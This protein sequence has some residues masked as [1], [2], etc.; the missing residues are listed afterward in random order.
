[1][2]LIGKI[3]NTHGLKG[4]VKIKPFTD[5]PERF[6]PKSKLLL[7]CENGETKVLSVSESFERGNFVFVRF[8]G[9]NKIDD[10]LSLINKNLLIQDKDIFPLPEDTYYIHDLIGLNVLD[11]EDN[12]IGVVLDVLQLTSNDIY[13]AESINGKKFLIPALKHFIEKIDIE[14]KVLKLRTID[15]ILY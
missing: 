6:F 8:K 4:F 5:F 2:I 13:E 9:F 11:N 3:I 10:V 12:K 7:E 14:E 1:M 15:G